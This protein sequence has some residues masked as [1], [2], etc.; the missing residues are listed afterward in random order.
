M[1]QAAEIAV[2]RDIAEIPRGTW[3]ALVGRCGAAVF[4]RHD[5]L[6]VY[7]RANLGSAQAFV[8]L[9]CADP[10]RDP[11]D[12]LLGA[13]PAYLIDGQEIGRVL[14]MPALA[15]DPRPL[16]V[17]HF[18]HCYDTTLLVAGADTAV[19]ARL[20]AEFR[21][22]GR[23]LGAGGVALMNLPADSP[24]VPDLAAIEGVSFLVG[25]ARWQ[26]AVSSF[27]DF[28]AYLR[29]MAKSTRKTLRQAAS[30]AAAAGAVITTTAY[31]PGQGRDELA[32]VVELCVQ[33]AAK[34][35]SRY[36]PAAALGSFV[37]EAAEFLVLR[38]R[39]GGATLAASICFVDDDVMHT[40]AGGALYP[41]ALNWSPNHV[42]FH[43]E[44]ELAFRLGVA[45]LECGRRN[46][47]F[48]ARHRLARRELVACLERL[49][50]G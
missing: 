3:D 10:R 15:A 1:K 31:A 2:A 16:L 39:L 47:E 12:A 27:A 35:G 11:K 48:K 14:G 43:A 21:E 18:P 25:A 17:S 20:W 40:W 24:W 50:A 7:Q 8:Y 49:P 19:A 37:R 13:L 4:Y 33:T 30:R 32:D 38:I 34:H 9:T 22:Q 44:V 46:D 29:T 23:T 6:R 26:L 28:D 36:Y 45:R 41:A 42:L 5:F